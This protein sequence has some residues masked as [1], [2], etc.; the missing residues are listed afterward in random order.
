[1]SSVVTI[2]D[3]RM[4]LCPVLVPRANGVSSFLSGKTRCAG[5]PSVDLVTLAR[6]ALWSERSSSLGSVH[7]SSLHLS[8]A[9]VECHWWSD[10]TTQRSGTLVLKGRNFLLF[11]FTLP[12]LGA[13]ALC[14]LFRYYLFFFFSSFGLSALWGPWLRRSTWCVC[15]WKFGL[16]CWGEGRDW[17]GSSDQGHHGGVTAKSREPAVCSCED[18]CI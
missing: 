5:V 13:F 12:K 2:S 16:W 3:R 18:L 14:A 17:E 15:Q 10:V 4:T 9:R 11:D 1:M 7:R 8:P 6:R